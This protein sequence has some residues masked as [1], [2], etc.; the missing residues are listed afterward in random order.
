MTQKGNGVKKC[1]FLIIWLLATGCWLLAEPE[2]KS[3]KQA[4]SDL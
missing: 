4:A 2:T 3:Q 1:L